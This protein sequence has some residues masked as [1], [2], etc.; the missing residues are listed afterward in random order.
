MFHI[1]KMAGYARENSKAKKRKSVKNNRS[2]TLMSETSGKDKIK[3]RTVYVCPVHYDPINI[4]ANRVFQL[5]II[6]MTNIECIF[7]NVLRI[8]VR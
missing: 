6:S 2:P 3:N 4:N 7:F 1:A 8:P 5:P